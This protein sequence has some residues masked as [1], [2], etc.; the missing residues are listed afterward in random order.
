[1]EMGTTI[2]YVTHDQVEALTMSTKIA[3]FKNGVLS[4]VSTPIELYMNP[5]DL[6]AA[7]FIGN[8]RIN[9]VPGRAVLNN[10]SLVVSSDL[11]R[12]AFDGENFTG[13]PIPAGEFDCVMGVRPEQI[14]ILREGETVLDDERL[15][16]K[17]QVYT[18]QPAGSETL[19]TLKVGAV[20]L[21]TKEIGLADYDGD[22]TVHIRMSPSKIN[23]YDKA[24]TRLIKSTTSKRGKY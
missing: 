19:V 15:Y 20:E 24:T 8:P 10:G 21:L 22:E 23:V 5:I 14:H 16:V 17:A 2:V 12:I 18:T 11:G 13:E 1:M 9:F 6:N 7:D 3:L 4:Q